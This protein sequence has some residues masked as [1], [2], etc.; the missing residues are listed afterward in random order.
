MKRIWL[1]VLTFLIIGMPM[2][3]LP[4]QQPQ[5]REPEIM[6]EELRDSMNPDEILARFKAGNL[7]FV[8]GNFKKHNHL[9]ERN[10]TSKEQHPNAIVLSCIDSRMP[11]EII[12][13]KS[14]GDTFN[15]KIAGNIINPDI[16]GSMEYATKVS[17]AK[18]I[19][20]MGHTNCGA[21]KSAINDMHLGNITSL[22]KHIKPA[23]NSITHFEN[24]TAKNKEF[25]AAV[26]K[27]NVILAEQQI[28]EGS[29]IIRQLVAEGKVK[30]VGC[31]YHLETGVAEFYQ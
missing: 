22:L 24:R 14:I 13:D 20:V 1:S 15:A 2:L 11:V 9:I 6:T 3:A 31:M 23:V 7:R 19:V 21:I 18:L 12:F 10:L 25:I 29:P 4:M 5:V 16:L 30:I 28:L 8:R 26:A 17:G 27:R